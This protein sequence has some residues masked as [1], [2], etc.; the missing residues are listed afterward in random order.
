[1]TNPTFSSIFYG[2][3][4]NLIAAVILPVIS[5]I[6][7][8]YFSVSLESKLIIFNIAIVLSAI[9]VMNYHFA[10]KRVRV[11]QQQGQPHIYLIEKNIARHIPEP[12]TFSYL[13]QIYG[14]D[15]KDVEVITYDEFREQ[16]SSGSTLPSIIPYCQ[17]FHNQRMKEQNAQK[18]N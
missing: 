3:V 15:K 10:P 16:F 2:V 5:I 12:T 14:F 8:I 4:S 11:V 17:E 7:G 9:I 1:M 13:G 18:G 6:V